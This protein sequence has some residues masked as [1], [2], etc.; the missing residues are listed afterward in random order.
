[1]PGFDRT[2]PQGMG[3]MTG[4]ARGYCAAAAGNGMIGR[5]RA[6]GA[7]RGLGGGFGLSGR[8][9]GGRGMGRGAFGG[10]QNFGVAG[11]AP[12]NNP[13]MTEEQERSELQRQAQ[14]IQSELQ[15]IQSRITELDEFCAA[16][17]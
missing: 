11:A 10:Y 17:S 3:S 9:P 15:Q 6:G 12:F 8:G 14:V 16:D 7:G 13:P 4:G 5:G 2:G 1:M